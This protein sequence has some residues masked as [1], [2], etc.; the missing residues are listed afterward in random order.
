MKK[1]IK[2]NLVILAG[3]LCVILILG[4]QDS[5]G[6][7]SKNKVERYTL[8]IVAA[9]DTN[10]KIHGNLDPIDVNTDIAAVAKIYAVLKANGYED[11]NIYILYAEKSNEFDW[12]EKTNSEEIKDIKKNH[13]SNKYDNEASKENIT[14]RINEIKKKVDDNDRFI[15][16]LHTHGAPKTGT[17]QLAAGGKWTTKEI[18]KALEGFKSKTNIFIFAS[19]FSGVILNATDF[20]NAVSFAITSSK[21]P[22]WADRTF[23]NGANFIQAL[24]NKNLD[25][26]KNN[27]I[28][29]KE[30]FEEVEKIAKE[31]EPK[32]REYVKTKYKP[33][34]PTPRGV[35][36]SCSIIPKIKIGK[37]YEEANLGEST[38]PKK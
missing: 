10:P 14:K 4:Q 18:Q 5:S 15:F 22:G 36:E 26:N 2:K 27:I 25:K 8:L 9:N 16:Y 13:F 20:D 12:T 11:K 28:E 34:K 24:A 33:N 19:C 35:M 3:I 6:L 32:W 37:N 17:L 31:Y 38:P 1:L 7:Q 23:C 30:A 29:A 21:T